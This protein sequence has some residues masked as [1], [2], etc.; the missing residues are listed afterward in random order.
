MK[1]A[2]KPAGVSPM[3]W[4]LR[5]LSDQELAA[6]LPPRGPARCAM[7]YARD[8]VMREI[9]R[10]GIGYGQIYQLRAAAAADRRLTNA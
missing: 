10:R 6:A 9:D 2:P 1:Q 4:P 3:E 5:A 7:N 8:A